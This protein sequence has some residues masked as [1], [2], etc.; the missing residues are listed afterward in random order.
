MIATG[1]VDWPGVHIP[2]V[3]QIYDPILDALAAENISFVETKYTEP[4]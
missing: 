4:L 1:E 2:V 3:P